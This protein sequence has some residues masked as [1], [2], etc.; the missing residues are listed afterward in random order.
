MAVFGPHV[1][2]VLRPEIK[3]R[4]QRN[5]QRKEEGETQG[6]G[7]ESA[8][9]PAPIPKLTPGLPW[10]WDP[11]H[12]GPRG[13]LLKIGRVKT[14]DRDPTAGKVSGSKTS[15]TPAQVPIFRECA[16]RCIAAFASLVHIIVGA[17]MRS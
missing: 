11:I 13:T 4:N 9:N 17:A 10:C 6:A 12:L 3:K 1:F 14:T 8:Q 2:G 7:Y 16:S 5:Q 15:V